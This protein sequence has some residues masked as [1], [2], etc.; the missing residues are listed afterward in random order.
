MT[1]QDYKEENEAL[2]QRVADL[3]FLPHE[4]HKLFEKGSTPEELCLIVAQQFADDRRHVGNG[5]LDV[6]IA[7]EAVTHGDSPPWVMGG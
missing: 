5:E 7:L 1:H 6:G 2:R 4:F 3:E